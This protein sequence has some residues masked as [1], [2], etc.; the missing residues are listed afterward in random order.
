M[1]ITNT[2]ESQSKVMEKQKVCAKYRLHPCLRVIFRT[3]KT[4]NRTFNVILV[5]LLK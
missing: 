2:M 3:V 5:N 1:R 4:P